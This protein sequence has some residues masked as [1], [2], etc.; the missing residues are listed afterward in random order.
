ML[1][2]SARKL[3]KQLFNNKKDPK[4]F[5][6]GSNGENAKRS[7][8]T[9]HISQKVRMMVFSAAVRQASAPKIPEL[10]SQKAN[11][12]AVISKYRFCFTP[13]RFPMS[14][15]ISDNLNFRW[16]KHRSLLHVYKELEAGIGFSAMFAEIES[17]Q[18]FLFG[19]PDPRGF[20]QDPEDRE[21]RR[22][23]EC[24]HKPLHAIDSTA[25]ESI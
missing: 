7:D 17:A 18:F 13:I 14:I 25:I 5:E 9:F 6:I 11:A 1:W 2:C 21:R 15:D 3:N 22:G 8:K 19:N 20:L 24:F 16:K 12:E 4:S 10:R 23:Q